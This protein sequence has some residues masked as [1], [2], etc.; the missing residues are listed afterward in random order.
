[1]MLLDVTDDK[2]Y[3]SGFRHLCLNQQPALHDLAFWK[4]QCHVCATLKTVNSEQ[5]YVLE[6]CVPFDEVQA[7]ESIHEVFVV[8]SIIVI[9]EETELI[10]SNS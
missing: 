6:T 2:K 10:G 9:H 3:V 5:K 7:Q 1:V 4:M 8:D